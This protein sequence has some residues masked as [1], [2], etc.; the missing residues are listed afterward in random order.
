MLTCKHNLKP[1]TS[2]IVECNKA[3]YCCVFDTG[4][5][6]SLVRDSV[7]NMWLAEGLKL[8]IKESKDIVIALGNHETKINGVINLKPKIFGI[9]TS[10]EVPFAIVNDS[11]IPCCFLLGIN[12]VKENNIQINFVVNTLELNYN[13]ER[14]THKMQETIKKSNINNTSIQTP[15]VVGIMDLQND[16]MLTSGGDIS[17]SSNDEELQTSNELVT[18]EVEQVRSSNV[19]KVIMDHTYDNTSLTNDELDQQEQY[20]ID[21]DDEISEMESNDDEE[22][23]LIAKFSISVEELTNMQEK[24]YALRKS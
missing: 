20:E 8:D 9:S 21:S 7:I 4:A 6:I 23:E 10:K 13:D 2:S 18:D 15:I 14:I 5:Q 1:M 24:Y 16:E 12:I 19:N 17:D 3:K 11:T 22:E